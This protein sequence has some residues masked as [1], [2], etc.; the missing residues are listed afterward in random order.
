MAFEENITEDD[1]LNKLRE[2]GLRVTLPRRLI[3][4]VLA[5]SR[6]EFI[7]AATII[8][9]VKASAGQIDSSTVY[10]TLDEMQS[11]GLV[12]HVHVGPQVS[13]TWHLSSE[14]DHQH[15]V[16]EECGKTTLVPW[17]EVEPLYEHFYAKYGFHASVHHLAIL[18]HCADD[19][20]ELP[21]HPHVA[22][23]KGAVNVE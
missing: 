23:R 6:Y 12:H 18:G 4:R 14:D 3:S 22:K 1:L 11:I 2:A 13:G 15:L 10:R 9:R 5:D 21:D 17:S 20:D 16:C 19:C 7:N 8:E